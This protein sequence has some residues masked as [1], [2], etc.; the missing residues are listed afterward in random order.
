MSAKKTDIDTILDLIGALKTTSSG[1]T[2]SGMVEVNMYKEDIDKSSGANSYDSLWK[3]HEGYEKA[4]DSQLK[5]E[6]IK[7]DLNNVTFLL[8]ND[9]F[10][11]LHYKILIN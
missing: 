5:K 2:T 1:T 3:A 6:T 7:A 9:K 8:K 11:N 10:T 4:R